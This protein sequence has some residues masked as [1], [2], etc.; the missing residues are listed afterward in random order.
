MGEKV[1]AK[2]AEAVP[3]AL[4]SAVPL[5]V[6]FAVA[7]GVKV[8]W[9]EE[10]VRSAED[11]KRGELVAADVEEIEA[12][13]EGRGEEVELEEVEAEP[14]PALAVARLLPVTEGEPLEMAEALPP[15]AVGVW[16]GTVG[17]GE[18]VPPPSSGVGVGGAEALG[19]AL[20]RGALPVRRAEVL[21]E[22]LAN[23]VALPLLVAPAA[24]PVAT[25]PLLVTLLLRLGDALGVVGVE[26]VVTGVREVVQDSE[27]AALDEGM[28]LV[29][30]AL[31]LPVTL[32]LTERVAPVA[33][34]PLELDEGGM[35]GLCAPEPLTLDDAPL[36]GE[37]VGAPPLSEGMGEAESWAVREAFAE[38]EADGVEKGPVGL[39]VSVAT[40]PVAV[41][42]DVPNSPLALGEE[43]AEG[44]GA[45]ALG[46]G[47]WDGLPQPLPVAASTVGENGGVK[48]SKGEREA[49][50]LADREAEPETVGAPTEG[51]A[52]PLGLPD[53]EA[54]SPVAE[55]VGEDEG[56]PVIAAPVGVG[57][58]LPLAHWLADDETEGSSVALPEALPQELPVELP[59]PLASLLLV[60]D[61]VVAAEA[62]R[63]PLALL[64]ELVE[65][66][67][68]AVATS[69]VALSSA[70]PVG[71]PALGLGCREPLALSERSSLKE[72][73]GLPDPL[74]VA[75]PRKEPEVLPLML[76]LPHPDELALGVAEAQPLPVGAPLLVGAPVP[77][78]QVVG[79]ADCVALRREVAEP[80]LDTVLQA[81]GLSKGDALSVAQPVAPALRV[82]LLVPDPEAVAGAVREVLA[83]GDPET[84]AMEAVAHNEGAAVPLFAAE[85]VAPR[86]GV[87]V[88]LADIEGL[89]EGKGDSL[90]RTESEDEGETDN[91]AE[92]QPDVEGQG[93][94]DREGNGEPEVLAERLG[95]PVPLA[96]LSAEKEATVPLAVPPR[97]AAAVALPQAPP[98]LP[99]G[100][101]GEGVGAAELVALLHAAP[102]GEVAKLGE[103]DGV[104][105]GHCDGEGV[106]QADTVGAEA[107]ALRDTVTV[108]VVLTLPDTV[109][110][111]ARLL[112]PTGVR[113]PDSQAR[114]EGLPPAVRVTD[115][116][117]TLDAEVFTDREAMREGVSAAVAVPNAV[118]VTVLQ[119]EA[120]PFPLA[121]AE[122]VP[123]APPPEADEAAEG[124]AELL[125][126]GVAEAAPVR[127]AEPLPSA[128]L[129]VALQLKLRLKEARGEPLADRD[130]VP[131]LE[132]LQLPT[133]LGVRSLLS[134]GFTLREEEGERV[135]ETEAEGERGALAVALLERDTEGEAEDDM[136]RP[137][138]LLALGEGSEESVA[139]EER[140][141]EGLRLPLC[142][143]LPHALG[144]PLGKCGEAL[145]S[146][147]L[148][149]VRELQPL[150][151]A[152]A[153]RRDEALDSVLPEYEG[154]P[155]EV[156]E[157]EGE[158]EVEFERY[159][160]PLPLALC[161]GEREGSALPVAL[162]V[163]KEDAE[164]TAL[165][166]K[167]G[168]ELSDVVRVGEAEADGDLRDVAVEETQAEV[169][170]DTVPVA[171]PEEERN[172]DSE[173]VVD[174]VEVAQ[175]LVLRVMLGDAEAD[176]ERCREAVEDAQAEAERVYVSLADAD[177]ERRAVAEFVGLRV[178]DAQA[179]ALSVP[180]GEAETEG[181]RRPLAVE[182]AQV[183]DDSV[184]LLLAVVE[185]ERNAEALAER[186]CDTEGLL[187]I[188]RVPLGEAVA[189]SERRELLLTDAQA[190]AEREN[191]TLDEEEGERVGDS[192]AEVQGELEGLPLPLLLRHG[193]GLPLPVVLYVGLVDGQGEG[194]RLPQELGVPESET[195]PQAVDV[196]QAEIEGERVGDPVLELDLQAVRDSVPEEHTL[197]VVVSVR[198]SVP[199]LVP[200]EE[201]V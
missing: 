87:A 64:A 105:E 37:A 144:V 172:G 85:T 147:L 52:P 139:A 23:A 18:P 151:E 178:A 50:P 65:A 10:G 134:D 152:L 83:L 99:V 158:G 196:T 31:P 55:T 131:V 133:E 110:A 86:E 180:L 19:E 136:L 162:K 108:A 24:L 53:S 98:L 78:A 183:V 21:C 17:E 146:A 153:L 89:R 149:G 14:A 140:L 106:A 168:L 129:G 57:S 25:A 91:E 192:V 59:L 188:L 181:E 103:C 115:G 3:Q 88:P 130:G 45:A 79:E 194:D 97:K 184:T 73:E 8:P 179:L 200:V 56:E 114:A 30:A 101:A 27:A 154:L 46:D 189:E 124:V 32:P 70:V 163:C 123:P 90:L 75:L 44:V 47:D 2:E 15:V 176:S 4:D 100:R 157:G 113:V 28:V 7:K 1:A 69:A 164:S 118:P 35:E 104:R 40:P 117:A 170:R 12:E 160:V 175:L 72:M 96:E 94:E 48:E 34:E 159:A 51:D 33:S 58:K 77:E 49:P 167:E 43:Q 119:L 177:G 122:L 141:L 84:V 62:L 36:R 143:T 171:D 80:E 121:E 137:L 127:D 13:P 5:C 9:P 54:T 150:L 195:V 76:R 173:F 20:L 107:E 93:V 132:A 26:S 201:G 61:G 191:V 138:L 199:Q 71:P 190:D 182:E 42:L 63:R 198:D 11:V 135:G 161:G 92:A 82:A 39:E 197:A 186:Q 81:L 185:A 111:A 112:V 148:E 120:V 145:G 22:A 67:P 74:A 68:L 41:T 109:A 166:E 187:V 116:D 125:K 128:L 66:L 102:L 126:P 60:E 174:R 16:P 155:L 38:D 169:E 193:E 6:P 165:C 142:V 95:E 156:R 29:V